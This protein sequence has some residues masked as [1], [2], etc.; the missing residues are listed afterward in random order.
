V[1]NLTIDQRKKNM[2]SIRSFRTEPELILKKILKKKKIDFDYIRT[3]IPGKP[4]FV[5]EKSRLIIFVD[6]DFW[7]CHPIRCKFPKSNIKYWSKKLYKNWMRDKKVNSE[8][9]KS[10]WKI[11]RIWEY[12]LKKNPD[13]CSLLIDEAIKNRR[14]K[15]FTF[16]NNG[17]RLIGQ[18]FLLL[19]FTLYSIK[20]QLLKF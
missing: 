12:D 16:E 10:G 8:I 2:K 11:L 17:I 5:L 19:R 13:Y 3:N 7:H 20:S 4:D 9:K 14:K 18:I 1:D 6:S 15:L